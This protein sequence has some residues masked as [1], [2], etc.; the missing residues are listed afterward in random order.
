[1]AGEAI[2]HSSGSQRELSSYSAQG[3][4]PPAEPGER[5][6]VAVAEVRA[7]GARSR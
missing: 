4:L 5:N 1:M 7:R 3:F 2:H 6:V